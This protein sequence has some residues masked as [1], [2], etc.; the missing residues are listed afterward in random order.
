MHK[1]GFT[2]IELLVVIS[3]ISLLSSVILAALSSARDKARL[4]A[5]RQFDAST[6]HAMGD[7]AALIWNFDESSGATVSDSSGNGNTGSFPGAFTRS[8]N[9]QSGTGYAMGTDGSTQYSI[10][11]STSGFSNQYV[12]VTAWVKLTSFNNYA[13]LV[14]HMWANTGGWALYCDINGV[15]YFGLSGIG[16]YSPGYKLKLNTWYNI[17]GTYDGTNFILYVNGSEIGRVAAV[18]TVLDTTGWLYAGYTTYGFIDDVKVYGRSV[19]L[20]QIQKLYAE[21]LKTHQ[22]FAYKQ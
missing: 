13:M 21:G 16:A 7:A 1:R 4:A 12:T 8:S 5:G 2:L 19:T 22:N 6:Y 20:G 15:P 18:G 10:V 17:A 3:I 14:S 11:N 9:T